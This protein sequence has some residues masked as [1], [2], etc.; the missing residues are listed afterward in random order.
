VDS[1]R[2]DQS[3]I[4][5]LKD[6]GLVVISGCAHA[7][8]VNSIRYAQKITGVPRIHAIIG[9][10]H[11]SG[12]YFSKIITP[13]ITD[14]ESINPAYIIPMHC[15]GWEAQTLFAKKMP[16]KFILS[17]VGTKYVFTAR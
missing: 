1:F 17:T 16:D 15:T 3:V 12:P 2:D 5:N 7:G 8:I 6:Q 10:F 11:L 4:I 9:G 13:T 14:L